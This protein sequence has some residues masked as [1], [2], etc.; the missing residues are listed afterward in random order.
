[1][2]TFQH[3]PKFEIINGS[4]IELPKNCR[5]YQVSE[6]YGSFLVEC[7]P[8]K[9]M[10]W[11]GPFNKFG[12][13]SSYEQYFV[14]FPYL[15]FGISYF[16]IEKT[17]YLST[18]SFFAR[19]SPLMS[20]DDILG[21]IGLPH[22]SIPKATMS[23]NYP[24]NNICVPSSYEETQPKDLM[25]S[26]VSSFWQSSFHYNFYSLQLQS[27]EKVVNSWQEMSLLTI[28]EA[29]DIDLHYHEGI[30]VATFFKS[31]IQALIY[32][33]FNFR[34]GRVYSSNAYHKVKELH[35]LPIKSLT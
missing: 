13:E 23:E 15:Y 3:E 11:A 34:G 10:I 35:L 29:L 33:D 19:N 14:P 7:N 18:K 26:Y 25:N 12:S 20:V 30:S 1:M 31:N 27:N 6:D 4:S 24:C 16:R 9:R 21:F 8:T 32:T 2:I 28:H 17:F 22:I 5:F